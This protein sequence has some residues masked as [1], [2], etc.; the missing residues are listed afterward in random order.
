MPLPMIHFQVAVNYCGEEDLPAPFFLGNIAPDAIHMRKNTGREDKKKTHLDIESEPNKWGFAQRVYTHYISK[1]AD[2]EWKWFVRGY[3]THLLTDY[4]WL[5]SVYRSFKEKT[6]LDGL[7]PDQKRK[8]YYRDTDQIDFL[9][10]K[11]KSWTDE[12][13]SKLIQSKSFGLEPYVSS[14][15]VHY[16]RYRTIHWFDLLAQEPGVEP[17]YITEAMTEAFTTD[18]AK[19]IKQIITGWDS[20]VTINETHE[21]TPRSSQILGI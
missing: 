21:T 1:H 9:Y 4:I 3:F 15:E 12:V 7:D 18:A 19:R 17:R 16:W 20:I 14:D 6:T 11:K 5:E 2:E 8:A 13:W 10:Y